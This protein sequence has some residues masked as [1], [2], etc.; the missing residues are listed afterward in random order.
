VHPRSDSTTLRG[1]LTRPIGFRL[2]RILI[3]GLLLTAAGL[4]VHGLSLGPLA[5]G[6]ILAS[7]RLQLVTIEVE[8]IMGLWLLSG[9]S[10][11]AAWVAA[12]GF[13]SIL[14]SASLYLALVGQGSCGCMGHIEVH[15]WITFTLDVAIIGLLAVNR[16]TSTNI[17]GVYWRRQ[18]LLPAGGAGALLSVFAAVCLLVFDHPMTAL[19]RLR[20][21]SITLEPN[22][23][24]LGSGQLG[25]SRVFHLQVT[26]LSDRPVCIV[27]GTSDCACVATESL[28]ITLA[29]L[30]TQPIEVRVAFHGSPG[31]FQH[32][33]LLYTDDKL[34]RVVTARFSGTLVPGER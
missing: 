31:Q 29:K 9:W 15:P 30:E 11:R 5:Q 22:V 7:P 20:G 34:Q 2:V 14:A 3:G 21:E 8:I 28:P 17:N 12:L 1:L 32:T 33:F 10:A 27:G 24:D 26:N 16:P 13:F 23:A 4:K 6:T 18:F 25:E 19:Q